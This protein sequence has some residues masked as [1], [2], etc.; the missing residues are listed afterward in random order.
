MLNFFKGLCLG[1]ATK[2]TWLVFLFSVS[3]MKVC[4]SLHSDPPSLGIIT[5]CTVQYVLLHHLFNSS[6]ADTYGFTVLVHYSHVGLSPSP[7]HNCSERMQRRRAVTTCQFSDEL[8]R[9]TGWS[10]R[11]IGR[12]LKPLLTITSTRLRHSYPGYVG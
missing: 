12:D 8:G 11:C 1:L 5:F 7:M 2:V 9:I 6:K 4:E 3:S 10:G